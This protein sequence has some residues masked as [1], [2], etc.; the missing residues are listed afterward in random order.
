MD[1]EIF[2]QKIFSQN[3]EDG[4]TMKL[5]EL[6]YGNEENN[7]KNNKNKYYVEFGV[8]DGREC[9]TRILREKYQWQGLQMDGSNEN[10]T[11]HLK[12]EFITRENI[13]ELFQKYQ[14]PA[15]INLLSVDIDYN[16]FY[17]LKAILAKYT[18]DI[19]IC[20]YNATH[21]A[22]DDKIIIYDSD[23]MWDGSNYFGTSLSALEKLGN[24]YNY[25]LIYCDKKGVNCFFVHNALL[26]T[27]KLQFKD[28]GDICKLY[29]PAKYGPGP[30]GGH[31]PDPYHRPYITYAESLADNHLSLG[32]SVLNSKIIRLNR[33]YPA[34]AVFILHAHPFPDTFTTQINGSLLKVTRTDLLEN[35]GWAYPHSGYIV[36]P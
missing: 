13:V 25:S 35:S 20:E 32:T 19:I 14:V 22:T 28:F 16:D 9:N 21:L 29:R 1:L 33:V 26:F 12:K 34:N 23:G 10:A 24:R 31:R 15:K 36:T 30:N 27:K 6:I 18:C 17:C 7:N 3:G 11:I 5:I 4:V 8:E 2:E